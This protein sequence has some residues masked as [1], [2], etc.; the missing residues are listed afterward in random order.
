MSTKTV[1]LA[2]VAV[3][4]GVEFQIKNP[5]NSDI[6]IGIQANPGHPLLNNGG[7]DLPAGQQVSVQAPEDWAGRFWGRTGCD[8]N[9]N[10]CE[11][12]DCGNKL[13]CNGAGGAPPATLVE[14][15]LKGDQGLDFYDVSLVDG[16]N[17]VA[18][19]EPIGGQGDGSQYSCKKD[20]CLNNDVINQCPD[21]LQVK[22][23]QGT[24]IACNSAC[25]AFNT[26]QY[27]CRGAYGT[28]ETCKS[29]TWP[30]NYPKF[31]K[32]RCPDAYSYAYDDHKSTF[33]CK[34][35]TYLVTFGG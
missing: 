21:A 10:H 29:E 25:N 19:I 20:A 34:A 16:F 1:F 8:P 18:S 30:E 13:E 31:F 9:S 4:S 26:D 32:D 12:G 6:W 35:E 5:G 15:T 28:P 17:T 22:N 14:I 27:C 33:T 2:L 23:G 3:C 24:V 11:T 7:F